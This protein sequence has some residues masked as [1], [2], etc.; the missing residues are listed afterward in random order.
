M[1][2]TR[3][4]KRVYVANRM[5]G[6]VS[7]LAVD[8]KDVRLVTTL[9]LAPPASLLSHIALSADGTTAIATRNGDAKVEI[10]KLSGDSISIVGT[11]DVAPR[12]YAAAIHPGGKLAVVSSLGDPNGNG[13]LTLIDL[14]VPAGKV[15]ATAD[16]GHESLEGMML[17]PD[18]KWIAGVTHGGSTRPRNAPQY[19][20]NGIVVL[21]RLD[22]TRLTKVSEAPI[23]VW[24]QGAAFSTDG[25][26]L[27]VENMI[28]KNVMVFRNDNGKLTDT[29]QKI[30]VVGG[31]AAIRTSN[32]L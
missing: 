28:Q 4:G 14:T 3:D 26:T 20:P 7:I 18:G 29:G 15:V 1:S 25:R 13:I 6:S 12:P 10:L 27:L 23:G 31:A 11:V 19:R 32:S 21:Y 8:G 30:D 9:A 16:V 24:S 17:S 2:I 22:G 5:A